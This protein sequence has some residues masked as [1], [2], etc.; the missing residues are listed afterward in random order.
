MFRIG[1]IGFVVIL[2]LIG[3]TPLSHAQDNTALC[4]VVDAID[5]PIDNLVA[6]YDDFALYRMRFGGNHVGIDI[7]FDRW[8][9]PVA[10]AA[11]GRVTYSNPEGWDTEKGVVILEHTFPDGSVAYTLYGHMEQTDTL[12]FPQVGQCVERGDILGGIGWPSRGRPHLHYEIRNF[13][14]D[15]GGP[16]YVPGNPLEEGW[17]HPLD[18]TQLWRARLSPAYVS[19]TTFELAPSL[20]PVFVDDQS[21]A[22]ASGKIVEGV[23]LDGALLWRVEADEIVTGLGALPAGRVIART[24]S[25]QVI[26]LQGGRYAALWTVEGPD[27]PFKILGETLIFATAGGG[28]AAYDVQGNPVWTRPPISESARVASFDANHV[29][30]ALS[31]R[32]DQALLWRLVDISGHVVYETQL[33][34]NPLVEPGAN[35]DWLLL[36]GGQLRR[37]NGANVQTIANLGLSPTRASALTVDIL[38][39]FYIYLGGS[40]NS[41][42]SMDATGNARWRIEYPYPAATLPPLLRTGNGCLLYSLDMDGMLNVFNTSDGALINQAQLYAGGSQTGNP[43]GRILSVDADE[44]LYV[45]AGFLTTMVFDGRTLGG[46]AVANCRLG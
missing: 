31:A 29:Q 35:G 18:F 46:E 4:G 32:A 40:D 9:E 13:L 16:G 6:G 44:R 21:Y 12:F 42:V 24:R 5:Y 25:G 8:G 19:S 33:Q 30:V 43:G 14:P 27:E 11:R 26:A 41:L 36:E 45:G 22:I 20:P 2:L 7:G 15:D 3:F 39:N 28:L 37:I 17:Y 38:G 1:R 23:S 10:A 34:G